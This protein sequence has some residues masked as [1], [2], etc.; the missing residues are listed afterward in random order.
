M[1]HILSVSDLTCGYGRRAVLSSFG[2]SVLSGTVTC[3]LGANGIGKTTLLKTILGT[4]P[5]FSGDVEIDGQSFKEM[6]VKERARKIS[7]VP[8]AHA[9]PFDFRVLDVVT[10]GRI[11][12][13]G[14]FSSPKRKDEELAEEKL[15]EL[16]I[17][18][19]KD[20]IFTQLSGGER[21]MVMIAR[22][23]AQEAQFMVL[24]EP[25]S[26]LD[27]GN[28][29]KVLRAVNIL[30]DK[31]Y[32]IVMT[33]HFPDHAFLCDANVI[34]IHP[35]HSVVSGRAEHII[36]EDSMRKTYG[37]PILIRKIGNGDKTM[38][39]CQPVV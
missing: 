17:A 32:G 6:S 38:R 39:I 7:Y 4:L 27:Y 9:Q 24:D 22:A 8:Q 11:S 18:D 13:V 37:V 15:E 10:L 3:I 19:L 16:G 36:T 25:T 35:D 30:K 31:G 14:S 29:V 12:H 2:T 20:R 34:M 5:A 23:L 33:T 28:Q 26:N 1:A 21:Q